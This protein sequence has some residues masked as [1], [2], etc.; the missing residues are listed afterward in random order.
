MIDEQSKMVQIVELYFCDRLIPE[1]KHEKID[2]FSKILREMSSIEVENSN[3]GA[4]Y[5]SK[6]LS[7]SNLKH[8]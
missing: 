1:F 6:V 4:S 2:N 3:V 7:N 8:F 5:W